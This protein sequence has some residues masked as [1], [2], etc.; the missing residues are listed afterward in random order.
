MI[1]PTDPLKK[2]EKSGGKFQA[3]AI[4][5]HVSWLNLKKNFQI[6]FSQYANNVA[7]F[8]QIHAPGSKYRYPCTQPAGGVPK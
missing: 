6:S 4:Q 1:C 5:G 8:F 3:K 7:P 2:S